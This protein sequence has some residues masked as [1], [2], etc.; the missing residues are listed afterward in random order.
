MWSGFGDTGP[1]H[2]LYVPWLLSKGVIDEATF[3]W[4][5]TGLSGTTYIDFGAPDAS[6]IGD[7]TAI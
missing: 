4:Y 3:S 7:G 1:N 5:M 2:A 6:I